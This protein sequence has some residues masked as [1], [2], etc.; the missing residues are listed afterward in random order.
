[1]GATPATVSFDP[2]TLNRNENARLRVDLQRVPPNVEL[3]L[4]MDGKLYLRRSAA[5]FD[6][7]NDDMFVPPGVHEFRVRARVGP[8]LKI[9][10][11]VSTDFE[12]KKRKTLRIEARFPPAM[13]GKVLT[14]AETAAVAQVFVSL[15]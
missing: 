8:L 2:L 4:V 10:N 15:R 14:P 12:A 6:K 1:M 7:N 11:I 9:S 3:I 5:D 13:R